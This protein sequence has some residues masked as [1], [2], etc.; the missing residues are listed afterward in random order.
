MLR[1]VAFLCVL[2]LAVSMGSV[3]IRG[4]ADAS[5]Q[6]RC[7]VA[8]ASGTPLNIRSGPDGHIIGTIS[9][10]ILVTI[11]DQLS[12]SGR[13]W[14]YVGRYEDRVPIG[15]VYRDYL[16]C[17]AAAASQPSSYVLDGLALGGKVHVGSAAYKEYRCAPSD[18]FPSFIWCHRE[19]TEKSN[20]G[21]IRLSTSILHSQGGIAVY[22]NRYIEPAYFGPHDIRREIDRLSAKIGDRPREFRMPPR[23]G[24]PN[25]IIAVWGKIKLEQLDAAEVSLVA[26]GKGHQ[27]LLVSFLGDLQRSAK[28]GVPVYRLSGGAGLLWAATFDRDG[29]GALRFLIIDASKIPQNALPEPPPPPSQAM[30]PPPPPGDGEEAY[31]NVGA[32]AITHQELS[33]LS[34]CSATAQFSDHT[35]LQLALIQTD[36]GKEWVFVVANPHWDGWVSKKS[37]HN[38]WLATTESRHLTFDVADDNKTLVLGAS[39]E[40]MNSVGDASVLQISTDNKQLLASLDMK[41]SDAA[42][43]TVVTCVGEHPFKRAPAPEPKET[44]TSSGTAFFVAPN[45]LLTNNHVVRE[46]NGPIHVRYP[47]RP[48]YPAAIFGLDDTNDLAL[49]HT[50][51]SNLSVAS[52][53]SGV[54]LGEPVAAYGFPYAGLLSSSGNFTVGNV[55]SLIGLGD[56]TRFLQLST[57]IQPGN[58]GGPVLDMS[59]NVVGVVR[60][61]LNEQAVKDIPQ[62]VNFAIQVPIVINFLSVRGVAAKVDLLKSTQTLVPSD[63]ADLAKKFTV[64]VYCEMYSQKTASGMG[65][66]LGGARFTQKRR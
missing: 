3:C 38:L 39:I 1:K 51:M 26:S 43:K 64:Q 6:D 32:W 55:T 19:K 28:A 20:R 4:W 12:V 57:P 10:G 45:L 58:S 52:F 47:D 7:V 56:D 34:G 46:C 14:V 61:R 36:T 27:G 66:K 18:K 22:V 33:N 16:N 41:D 2:I 13:S 59:G 37:Q 40:L 49:L 25:A 11:F 17:A 29:R 50:N 31:A 65:Q 23:E 53:H 60:A 62:N 5:A 21:E 30:S 35:V 24:L 63:V 15:W 8:D 42:I 9:N 48:S 54:R 44:T